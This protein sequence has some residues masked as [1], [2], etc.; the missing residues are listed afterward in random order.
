MQKLND[1]EAMWQP[2][3]LYTARNIGI[4]PKH[5]N[6]TAEELYVATMYERLKI[7]CVKETADHSLN[8]YRKGRK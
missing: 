3:M 5:R 6:A 8:K 4:C 2:R 1:G 7:N